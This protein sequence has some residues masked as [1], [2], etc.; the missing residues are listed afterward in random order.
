MAD[1]L[2]LRGPAPA[3]TAAGDPADPEPLLLSAERVAELLGIKKRTLWTFAA[4][5][6]L[7]EPVRLSAKCVRWRSDELAAWTAA[8]CP[9]RVTWAALRAART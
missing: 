9:D 8:G 5:G 1:I 2:P 4:A 3:P 6:K 7:P